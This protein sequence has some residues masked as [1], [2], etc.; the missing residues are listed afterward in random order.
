MYLN[1]THKSRANNIMIMFIYLTT[2]AVLEQDN[3]IITF[4]SKVFL[5]TTTRITIQHRSTVKSIS[6]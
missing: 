3:R 1:I 6:K 2:Y 4:K 5:T